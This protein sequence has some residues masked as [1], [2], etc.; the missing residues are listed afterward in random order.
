[1]PLLVARGARRVLDV[2]SGIGRHA[3][4]YA[5]AGFDVVAVDASPAGVDELVQSAARAGV[6]VD[7]RVAA[8]TALPADHGSIDHVLAWNVLYH[9]DAGVVRR[10]FTECRRVLA[11]GGSFQLTML[12][13]RHHACGAGRQIRPDTWVDER[14]V[15][16][17]SHPHFYVDAVALTAMLADAGFAVVSLADVDQHPPT[18]A[19]HWVVLAEPV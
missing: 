18:G 7:A 2:G 19:Y 4:A 17:K 8:F 12:S 16:D 5:R 14:S 3:L 9:G 10:S 13:K 6:T 15:S 11:G 1:M